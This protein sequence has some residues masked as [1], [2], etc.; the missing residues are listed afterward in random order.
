MPRDRLGEDQIDAPYYQ[1]YGADFAY[2]TS[3]GAH[4]F[5]GPVHGA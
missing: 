5:T 4:K 3:C 2:G 1:G